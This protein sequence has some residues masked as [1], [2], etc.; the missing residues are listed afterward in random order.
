L[1]GYPFN[2]GGGGSVSDLSP[3]LYL[4]ALGVY[5]HALFVSLT[6]GLPLVILSLLLQ[7][8]RTN[9]PVYLS[10]VKKVTAVLAVNFALGAITGTLVEFG[11]IQVWPGTILVIASFALTPLALELIAFSMEIVLLILFIVTLGRIK[12][13]Y[14]III[15]SL[16][17]AFALFSGV[18]ITAVNSW[19]MAPWGTGGIAQA[20]YPFMPA[21][22]P[23]YADAAK[24]VALKIIL[25]ASG[26]PLQEVLQ[27]PEASS[28]IGII[29]TDPMIAFSNPYALVSI[30]HNLTAAII[31]GSGVALAAW[32]Y[33]YYKTGD[34]RYLQLI[35]AFA[36]PLFI[37]ILIQPTVSGHYMGTMVVQYNPTKFALIEGAEKTFHNPLIAFLAYGDPNHPIIGFDQFYA[38]CDSMKDVALK[39]LAS[40]LGLSK[41]YILGLSN[42]LGISIDPKKLDQVL[43]T[44]VADVC[45]S[46]LDA[47]LSRMS[48]VHYSYFTKIAFGIVAFMSAI[49]IMS[50]LY[51]APVLT[52]LTRRILRIN[53]EDS[54]RRWIFILASLILLGSVMS[55]A[56]G[57]LVREVG[58]KPWT[59]YGLV[60]PSEVVSVSPVVYETSFVLFTAFIV[61]AVN[62]A[63]LFAIYI[64]ATREFKFL[65]LLK[66][67]LGV[68]G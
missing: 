47:A 39:D 6:L 55:S 36:I 16:Y 20:L 19:Q 18:L 46:D 38:Q 45:R 33:R 8:A 37:L 10:G 14:S 60:Y 17:W 29:L 31:I 49:A 34:R 48:L 3:L 30:V 42:K 23:L 21:Y 57:W 41:D 62:L 32:G 7:Y 52:R 65:D 24:L 35:K 13:L 64:V 12:A 51:D 44:S 66:K 25:L 4:S 68:G 5:L 28:E 50:I 40:S 61:L 58:R 53:S 59:V 1:K 54:E 67:G 11:L 56:L 27:V 63:G 43:D 26:S 9:N 2:I 22:G 15:I